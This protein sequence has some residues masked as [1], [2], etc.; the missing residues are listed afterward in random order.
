VQQPEAGLEITPI[1][2][3]WFFT[4]RI[5]PAKMSIDGS[6]PLSAVWGTNL[7][8]MAPG[9]HRVQ[10]WWNAYWFMPSNRAELDVDIARGQVVQLVYKPR[11]L[12]FL[13]GILQLVGVRGMVAPATATTATSTAQPAGWHPDP[14]GRHELRYWSG[15]TWTD[16]VADAGVTAKDSAG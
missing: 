3:W 6:A 15:T 4:V 1:V 9:R 5:F 13:A 16:D 7:V 14:S 8:P 11:W 12:V 10:F 2:S